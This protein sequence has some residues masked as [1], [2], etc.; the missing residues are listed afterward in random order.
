MKTAPKKILHAI[1]VHES[2]GAETVFLQLVKN[3]DSAEFIPVV[4]LPG[5]GWLY[6]QLN[7]AGIEPY[8]INMSGS[9]NFNYL[10]EL[11]KIVITEKIDLIHSHLFGSNIYSS[12]V[13]FITRTPVIATYHGVID[14]AVDERYLNIKRF[15]H[16]LGCSKVVFVSKF[17]QSKIRERLKTPIN[18]CQVIYNGVGDNCQHFVEKI[19]F[20]SAYGIE[21]EQLLIAMIGNV[22]HSK[23]Y[24]LLIEAISKLNNPSVKVVI[25]GEITD[26]CFVKLKL[27]VKDRR[28]EKQIVFA[29]FID[30]V[31]QFLKASDLYL[32]TSRDEGFSIST[33]EAMS[34]NIP[35]I[36]TRC[37]GPEE[38]IENNVNGVLIEN[39]SS[40]AILLALRDFINNS[41]K[42]YNLTNRAKMKVTEKFTTVKIMQQYHA[43]YTAL[44]L[45]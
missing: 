24:D 16:N 33:I 4:V 41:E 5:K 7:N 17:L 19:D 30:D 11:R 37:G 27:Q 31:N 21:N 14:I 1:D 22:N 42:Y 45:K 26:Q 43:L 2:G 18:K 32:L 40:D 34:L 8:V 36:A 23:G 3:I 9:F 10:R 6:Q 20:R 25:A 44:T 29:G 15:L 12:M 35:V 39:E 28:L 38:I 13:G